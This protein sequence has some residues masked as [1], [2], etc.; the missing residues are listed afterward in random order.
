MTLFTSDSQSKK[1]T[2]LL[3]K[4]SVFPLAQLGIWFP[5]LCCSD[6]EKFRELVRVQEKIPI[7]CLVLGGLLFPHSSS[8]HRTSTE[9]EEVCL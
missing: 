8:H 2:V 5:P 3:S 4:G 1:Y 9:D 7:I 6:M